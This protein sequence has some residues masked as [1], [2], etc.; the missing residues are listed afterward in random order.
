MKI[1]QFLFYLV[2]KSILQTVATEKKKHKLKATIMIRLKFLKKDNLIYNIALT[3]NLS[4]Q[5]HPQSSEADII[6]L[7]KLY[8]LHY[9]K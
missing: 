1:C 9:A 8:K 2:K 4:C 3:D 5:M 7:Y 6:E